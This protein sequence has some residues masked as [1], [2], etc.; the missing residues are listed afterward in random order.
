MR[1]MDEKSKSLTFIM[2]ISRPVEVVGQVVMIEFQYP[3]H[4]EKIVNDLKAK[5]LVEDCLRDALQ[6]TDVRID[7]TV[8]EEGSEEKETRARDM[9]S[10]ILRAF[11]GQIMD[12]GDPS[13]VAPNAA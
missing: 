4:R 1:L 8:K 3:Y 10:N 13:A 9:V 2:K 5:R 11:D 6:I 7:G 12:T